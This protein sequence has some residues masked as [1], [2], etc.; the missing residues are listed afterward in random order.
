MRLK[1]PQIIYCRP[2]AQ[3]SRR[4]LKLPLLQSS[5]LVN[6]QVCNYNDNCCAKYTAVCVIYS[7]SYAYSYIILLQGF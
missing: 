2:S 7:Y 3:P 4:G 1:L 6:L 5:A